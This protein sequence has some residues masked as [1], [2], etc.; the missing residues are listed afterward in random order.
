MQQVV[1]FGAGHV[2]SSVGIGP[3]HDFGWIFPD[4]EDFRFC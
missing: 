3:F 2:S 4:F 1:G